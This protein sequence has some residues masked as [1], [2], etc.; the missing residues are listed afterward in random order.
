MSAISTTSQ[1]LKG[2]AINSGLWSIGGHGAQQVLRL[3]SNL[4]L[5]RLLFPEVFGLMA[6]VQAVLAGLNMFSDVGLNAGVIRSKHGDEEAFL[7]TAWTIQVIR[8]V[9]L[10]LITCIAAWPMSKFYHQP[11]L[12]WLLPVVGLSSVAGG[13]SSTSLL[14]LQ[15]KVLIKPLIIKDIVSQVVSL[16]VMIAL[17]LVYRSVWALVAGIIVGAIT[18]F[19]ISYYLPML[20]RPHLVFDRAAVHELIR[21]GRWIFVSTAMSFLMKQGDRLIFGK[22]IPLE[23][24]GIYS[25]A[26]FWSRAALDAL[27]KV[28]GQVLYPVYS[29]FANDD[30]SSLRKKLFRV[31][32]NL[33]MLF[34]PILCMIVIFG[35]MLIGLLYDDRYAEAGWMLQ[36]LASGSI[37]SV[38]E[39]STTSVL[40]AV[41]D[42][43]R[44]MILQIARGF[45]LVGCMT[46]GGL[47][48]GFHGVLVGMAVSKV[49]DY[50]VLA[51]A[52]HRHRLWLPWLDFAAFGLS[53]ILCLLGLALTGQFT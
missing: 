35:H 53:V 3:G 24:L 1:S 30:I 9:G 32:S 16:V 37:A 36:V 50:P 47:M 11:E 13:L 41:G 4:I 15:R 12:M 6:L 8:G 20:Y 38:I 22:F 19:V 21:F 5:T 44:V 42:S 10:W 51:W 43:F 46:V 45:L 14:T 17:A 2:R 7:N 34:L 40:F 28:N 27:S 26:V 18:K 25:I 49:A 52:L 23:M 29:Q 33:L 31:R 39:L 48:W